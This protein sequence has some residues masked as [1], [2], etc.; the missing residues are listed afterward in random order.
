MCEDCAEAHKK[1]KTFTDHHIKEIGKFNSSD[2]QDYA[3]K[4]NICKKHEDELRYYCD[5]CK[6][7]ICRDCAILEHQDHSKISFEQGLEKKKSEIAV[8]MQE[9][10]VVSCRMRNHK[11]SLEKQRVRVENSIDRATNEVRR[12]AKHFISLIQQ[13]ESSM[14]E[15]LLRRRQS[16]QTEVS[17]QMSSVDE[18]LVDI[19]GSLEFCND[20]L[21]RNNLPE[22]LNVKKHWNE[23][24]KNCY[25]RRNSV[26]SR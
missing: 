24:L 26:P 22:I 4:T 19:N 9:V 21:E 2:V 18:K 1:W 7:C 3:R 13:H 20:I 25:H 15:E 5:K 6:I 11:E 14:T 10:Q 8:K 17:T 12:V 16:L 23:G